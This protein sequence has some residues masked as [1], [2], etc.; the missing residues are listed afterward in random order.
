MK[1]NPDEVLKSIPDYS[2]LIDLS[3]EISALMYKKLVLDSQIKEGEAIVFRTASSDA[4]F[5][6][7]GKPPSVSFIDNT[8]RHTG[9][10][11]ELLLLRLDLAK[12]I[13]D[14]EGKKIQM[15]IYKTMIDVWRTLCSNNRTA[16]I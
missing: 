3:V 4:K 10:N 11:G 15:D 2:E 6:Q 8:L 1:S 16:S 9:I 14:L 7:G 5:F 12:V 13:S